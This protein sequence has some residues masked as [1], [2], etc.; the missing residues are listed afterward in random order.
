MKHYFFMVDLGTSIF[1]LSSYATVP[2]PLEFVLEMVSSSTFLFFSSVSSVHTS[3]VFGSYFLSFS[4]VIHLIFYLS[5]S[6]LTSD[7]LFSCTSAPTLI[8][9]TSKISSFSPPPL[10]VG[11]SLFFFSSN[12]KEDD[13]LLFVESIFL[14]CKAGGCSFLY[15]R[16]WIFCRQSPTPYNIPGRT[17]TLLSSRSTTSARDLTGCTSCREALVLS[18]KFRKTQNHSSDGVR[19]NRRRALCADSL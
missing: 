12:I 10:L 14:T 15:T 9:S 3:S 2:K 11:A 17:T 18:P 16:D 13:S 7:V 5:N 4:E 19:Q 6:I 1:G 8:V